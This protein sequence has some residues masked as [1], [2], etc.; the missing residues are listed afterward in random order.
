M[1]RATTLEGVGCTCGMWGQLS[2]PFRRGL[3]HRPPAG[4]NNAT[5]CPARS[6]LPASGFSPFPSNRVQTEA[7]QSQGIIQTG[8]SLP[9]LFITLCSA[10]KNRER[11]KKELAGFP[12]GHDLVSHPLAGVMLVPCCPALPGVG[13]S[14][15][16]WQGSWAR[17]I[18]LKSE[19]GWNAQGVPFPATPQPPQFSLKQPEKIIHYALLSVPTRTVKNTKRHGEEAWAWA[20]RQWDRV[21]PLVRPAPG[22]RPASLPPLS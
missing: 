4:H 10:I 3:T 21:L 2:K 8:I 13:C 12:S 1:S 19:R 22:R 5:H 9:F 17:W 20:A 7:A 14:A 15:V 11:S 18:S 16:P 6:R